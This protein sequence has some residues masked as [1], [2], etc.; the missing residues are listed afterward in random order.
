MILIMDAIS[1]FITTQLIPPRCSIL[2]CCKS[3]MI[4]FISLWILQACA[5]GVFMTSLPHSPLAFSIAHLITKGP[6]HS[7]T[8]LCL[9]QHM[10]LHRFT[11][12]F[13]S[14]SKNFLLLIR[15]M[16]YIS[17]TSFI[18]PLQIFWP[19]IYFLKKS[20]K[21]GG[22]LFGHCLIFVKIEKILFFALGYFIKWEYFFFKLPKL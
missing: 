19:L 4:P 5:Y 22:L 21:K 3:I 18:F 20:F 8:M 13:V 12:N 9:A 7:S 16:Y 10:L 17:I 11:T 14:F 1:K 2:L 6:C 15:V